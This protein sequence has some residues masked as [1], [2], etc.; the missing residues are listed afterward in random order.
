VP[1]RVQLTLELAEGSFVTVAVKFAV[2][3]TTTLAEAG[4]TET[5][6]AGTVMVVEADLVGSAAAVALMVTVKVL[7]GGPGAV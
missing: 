1:D 7:A 4:K 5:P 3:L 6:M 2:A